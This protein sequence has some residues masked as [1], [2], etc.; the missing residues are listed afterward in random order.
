MNTMTVTNQTTKLAIDGMSCGHCVQAVT[1]A[2]AAVPGVKVKSVAV[3]AA[4]IETA[5]GWATA[6]AVNALNQAGYP[7]KAVANATATMAAHT[8]KPGGGCC[9]GAGRATPDA[10]AGTKASGGCCG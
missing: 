4:V 1:T 5:D 9:G 8:A 7:T 2:L 6:A 3:G 10:A